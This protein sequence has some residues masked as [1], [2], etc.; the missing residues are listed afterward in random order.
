MTT[1]MVISFHKPKYLVMR[2]FKLGT[3]CRV[4]IK[5]LPMLA[6]MITIAN[7]NSKCLDIAKLCEEDKVLNY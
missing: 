6:G 4:P 2:L 7:A 3:R 5:V 1:R